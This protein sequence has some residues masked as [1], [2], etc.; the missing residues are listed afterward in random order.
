MGKLEKLGLIV[1]SLDGDDKRKWIFTLTK[2]WEE[3][4]TALDVRFSQVSQQF[5]SSF[6]SQEKWDFHTLLGKVENNLHSK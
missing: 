1:R 6:S 2:K 4:I 3:A 5:F